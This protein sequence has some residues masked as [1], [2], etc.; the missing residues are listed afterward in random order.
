VVAHHG[1]AVTVFFAAGP[2]F[3]K[4]GPFAYHGLLAF[5][6]PVVI[7]GVYI[8]L[9]TWYMLKELARSSSTRSTVGEP[10]A[11]AADV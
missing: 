11:T 7:W 2:A 3:F 10:G 8:T 9:T 5:Y 1:G 4:S 6:I